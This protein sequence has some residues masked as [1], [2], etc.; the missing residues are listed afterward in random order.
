ME[1]GSYESAR[2]YLQEVTE[3][4]PHRSAHVQC[5]LMVLHGGEEVAVADA[6]PVFDPNF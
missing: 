2:R 4:S 5:R 3:R 6:E 1:A